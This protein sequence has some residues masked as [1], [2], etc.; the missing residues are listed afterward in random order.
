MHTV[1]AL[2]R[3]MSS[4]SLLLGAAF[5]ALAASRLA[6]NRAAMLLPTYIHTQGAG[7]SAHDAIRCDTMRY[8]APLPI[9]CL[10]V[11]SYHPQYNHYPY[12]Q[13]H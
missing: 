10:A 12:H 11:L 4:A 7:R 2:V 5:E 13:Y 8:D 9:Q 6:S 3:N 1:A